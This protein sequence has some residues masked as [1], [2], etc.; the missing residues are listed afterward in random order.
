MRPEKK[1]IS[2]PGDRFIPLR[3]NNDR[4]FEKFNLEDDIA[5]KA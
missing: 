5:S 3:N 4:M 1:S 2:C